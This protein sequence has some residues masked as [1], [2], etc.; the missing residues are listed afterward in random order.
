MVPVD[1]PELAGGIAHQGHGLA[2]QIL[3]SLPAGFLGE[4]DLAAPHLRQTDA[5]LGGL[6]GGDAHLEQAVLAVGW[7]KGLVGG[8]AQTHGSPNVAAI[9]TLDEVHRGQCGSRGAPGLRG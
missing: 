1:H 8:K 7:G 6:Q 5:H 2:A 9:L 3:P 4:I